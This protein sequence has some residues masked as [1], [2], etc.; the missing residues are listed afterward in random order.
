MNTLKEA[1]RNAI[2]ESLNS[3]A[4]EVQ[5]TVPNVAEAIGYLEGSFGA[6]N[7]R[8]KSDGSYEVQ[9]DEDGLQWNLLVKAKP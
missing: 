2:D 3:D 6:D 4:A 9:G 5:V 8:S 7:K 1:L